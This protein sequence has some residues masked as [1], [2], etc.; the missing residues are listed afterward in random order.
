MH[1]EHFP[2]RLDVINSMSRLSLSSPHRILIVGCAYGGISAIV[3]LLDFD[4]GTPRQPVYPSADF[5]GRTS[6]KGI[7]I[8]VIDERD[9]YCEC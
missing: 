7:E 3:N 6:K 2:E 5:S 4:K 9:G 8:T 1:L